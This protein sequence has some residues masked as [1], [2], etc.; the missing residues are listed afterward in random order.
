MKS[1]N[2]SVLVGAF[3]MVSLIA[4][5]ASSSGFSC[6]SEDKIAKVS[7]LVDQVN[8]DKRFYI[9][10]IALTIKTKCGDE[11]H[12]SKGTARLGTATPISQLTSFRVGSVTK[13]FT[14]YLTMLLVQAGYFSTDSTLGELLP[15]LRQKLPLLDV[16]HITVRHLLNQTS[17][18]PTYASLN[19]GIY[20]QVL[21]RPTTVWSQ[22]MIVETLFG[23][24]PLSVPGE[25][26]HYSNSNYYLLGMIVE[27]VTHK[28]YEEALEQF[29]VGPLKLRHTIAPRPGHTEMPSGSANGYMETNSTNA[30]LRDF[31]QVDPSYPRAAGS[32]I[33]TTED[34]A[35]FAIALHE[36]R[37]LSG[38]FRDELFFPVAQY[39]GYFYGAGV[40]KNE[41][42]YTIGH[43]GNIFGFECSTKYLL[44]NDVAVAACMNRSLFDS[45]LPA[46]SSI[47]SV[48][49]ESLINVLNEPEPSSAF[50]I[51]SD[52][53]IEEF[54]QA[55]KINGLQLAFISEKEF[56]VKK[57]GSNRNS[58]AWSD[59]DLLRIASVSKSFLAAL[60]FEIAD[61]NN[62]KTSDTLDRFFSPDFLPKIDLKKVRI[63][64][65]LRHSSG[66]PDYFTKEF[67]QHILDTP[68]LV[69]TEEDALSAIRLLAPEFDPGTS[70]HYSNTNYVLLGLILD[71][72][73]K[74]Q[75]YSGHPEL[76]RKFILKPVHLESTFYENKEAGMYN[77]YNI[78]KWFSRRKRLSKCTARIR[79]C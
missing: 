23:M 17:G 52:A 27:N 75:G 20:K 40:I 71:S 57:Y 64:D 49:M 38:K 66:I 7:Q 65:L 31:T 3:L 22:D 54:R 42:D 44:K 73:A 76:L 39:P 36:R 26:F 50:S 74:K 10:G 15:D 21:E 67:I 55:G 29:V 32:V 16:D 56:V 68:D 51:I 46:E 12:Y 72:L 8:A 34:L 41:N 37:L 6:L 43:D 70:I 18:I 61:S 53:K 60:F 59:H 13:A 62:L 4:C 47:D 30:T 78:V 5:K 58:M 79:S 25:T 63:G 35:E 48:L 14:G 45:T 33:S 28:S 9:P 11:F 24:K 77:P 69:K 19:L 1:R 2:C